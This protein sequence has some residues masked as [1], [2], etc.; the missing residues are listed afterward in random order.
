VAP[1]Q[2]PVPPEQNPVGEVDDTEHC[3]GVIQSERV[4]FQVAV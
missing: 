3:A 2:A 4:E 1:T